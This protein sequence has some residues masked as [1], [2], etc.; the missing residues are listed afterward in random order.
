MAST[1]KK[2][3]RLGPILE[4]EQR[5]DKRALARARADLFWGAGLWAFNS[6]E[7][8]EEQLRAFRRAAKPMLSAMPYI[9]ESTAEFRAR[10]LAEFL[11]QCRVTAEDPSVFS[12]TRNQSRAQIEAAWKAVFG[13]TSI[14]ARRAFFRALFTL[15]KHRQETEGVATALAMRLSREDPNLADRV[16][17]YRVPKALDALVYLFRHETNPGPR[18]GGRVERWTLAAHVWGGISGERITPK[19]L[20]R[21]VLRDLAT[22]RATQPKNTS[23]LANTKK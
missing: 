18:K 22:W 4:G 10:A 12:T 17:A 23:A 19:T 6:K 13:R 7:F 3:S 11:L 20:K 16:A 1:K 8:S 21:T 9:H 15:V 5:R 14:D 2:R